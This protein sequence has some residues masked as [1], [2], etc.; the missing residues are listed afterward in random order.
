MTAAKRGRPRP[1]ETL[2]RDGEL[3]QLL[4][5]RGPLTRSALAEQSGIPSSLV[6][7]S[8]TRLKRRGLIRRF[9]SDTGESTWEAKGNPS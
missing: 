8:L 6:Y 9:L 2:S 1:Q 7:L 3:H 4:E 5:D